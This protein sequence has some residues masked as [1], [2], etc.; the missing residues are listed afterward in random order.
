MSIFAKLRNWPWRRII[1]RIAFCAAVVLT[2]VALYYAI[3]R[4]RWRSAW[5]A[6]S[7]EARQRGVN[8]DYPSSFAPN[9]PDELNAA[10]VPCFT[11]GLP[12]PAI[13][14]ALKGT[15]IFSSR[16]SQRRGSMTAAKQSLLAWHLIEE[17]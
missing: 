7:A 1:G 4:W 13:L 8:L 6:Y 14:S 16:E 9:V 15:E 2:L 10:K 12:S 11:T 17:D 3:E 5:E